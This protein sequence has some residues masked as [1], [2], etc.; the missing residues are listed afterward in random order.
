MAEQNLC[1]VA[2]RIL[3]M[4]GR[5]DIKVIGYY[6]WRV[7]KE[8]LQGREDTIL[9]QA[10]LLLDA[11]QKSL[12]C[13]QYRLSD[14]LMRLVK[15]VYE[16]DN[17]MDDFSTAALRHRSMMSSSNRHRRHQLKMSRVTKMF[18]LVRGESSIEPSF[19]VK[20][21]EEVYGRDDDR[22]AIVKILLDQK[23]SQE[24][25]M[26]LPIIGMEGPGKT[27]L[28]RDVFD[29]GRVKRHFDLLVWVSISADFITRN[30]VKEM[31]ASVASATSQKCHEI[32]V[33]TLVKLWMAHGFIHL[34]SSNLSLKDVGYGFLR[35]L[36]KHAL[37]IK[38][39]PY[40]IGKLKHLR[41]LDLSGNEDI[42][43]LPDSITELLNLETLRLSSCF[44]F[45][46][47]PRDIGNLV[48][49]RHLEN[50]GCYSL[51][52]LP[53]GFGQLT[54]LQTLSQVILSVDASRC[55]GELRELKGL[56]NLREEI[57]IK[58]LKHQLGDQMDTW[59]K[60]IQKVRSLSIEWESN[61]LEIYSKETTLNIDVIS[62]LEE[63]VLDGFRGVDLFRP[64]IPGNL[65]KLSLKRCLK[66]QILPPFDQFFPI[67]VLVLDEMTDLEYVSNNSENQLV[68]SSTTF[69]PDLQEL[70]LTELPK[71]QGWWKTSSVE[72]QELP[73][74][75]CLSKLVIDNCPKLVS[76]PLFATLEEGLVLDSTC[77]WNPFQL[78]M[79]HK[80]ATAAADKASSS[81]NVHLFLL[82][83]LKSLC[84]VGIDK[85]DSSK[86]NEIAWNTL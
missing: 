85:F 31:V 34:Q 76:I 15:A 24:D 8:L 86:A 53:R 71:L 29:Y 48:N 78:T 79:E 23:E 75:R 12:H 25:V 16:A 57:L 18:C 3:G 26:V 9:R 28:A 81:S 41:Y 70:W 59:L 39:V 37:G 58:N 19:V 40:S 20:E 13:G 43:E 45:K 82:S 65:V 11:E 61:A 72:S 49:L 62:Y 80:L 30:M 38:N 2:N 83:K 1:V 21:E 55:D 84:I 33:Q 17:L 6:Q 64:S 14:W 32:D 27:K 46:K 44:R 51:T 22:E 42:T 69:F 74:F 67:K 10:P 63:L 54:N 50:D 68:S 7:P 60:S 47:L 52:S 5:E 66:C 35:V 73:S 56:V 77:C 4:L 36:D